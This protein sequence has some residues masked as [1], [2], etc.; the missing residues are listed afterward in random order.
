MAALLLERKP[1][2]TVDELEEA[3]GSSAE[4]LS[5]ESPVR[6]GK[7]LVNAAAS[8]RALLNAV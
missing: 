6:Y 1:T 7:G 8:L 2:A 4:P 5:A 3:I